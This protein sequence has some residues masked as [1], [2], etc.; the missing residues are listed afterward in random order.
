MGGELI[1]MQTGDIVTL[2]VIFLAI[3]LSVVVGG[4]GGF[5]IANKASKSDENAAAAAQAAADAATGAATAVA[6]NTTAIAALTEAAQKPLTLDA[7]TRSNLASDVPAGCLDAAASLT[8]ACLVAQC[9]RFGQS[10]AQRPEGCLDLLRDAR[11]QSWITVCGK[12]EAGKPDW[13][14]VAA[15]QERSKR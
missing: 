11:L 9:W 15:A 2:P 6:S 12:D 5:A 3:G 4:A 1:R 10:A 8:P 13:D 14:C 7:E